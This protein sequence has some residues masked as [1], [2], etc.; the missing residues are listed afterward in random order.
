MSLKVLFIL[1]AVFSL[2]SCEKEA[3]LSRSVILYENDKAGNELVLENEYLELRF[4]PQTAGIVLKEKAGGQVWMS[5]PGVEDN[6]ADMVTKQLMQS[7]FSLTYADGAGVGM[8]LYSGS[9]S[10]E[11]GSF[12]V[13]MVDGGLE[14]HYA[15]GNFARTYLFPAA[16]PEAR[17]LTFLE[18]I[19][20]SDRRK[21]EASYRLYDINNLRAADDKNALLTQ[22]PDLAKSK[23]YVLRDNTQEY[24]KDQIEEFFVGAGYTYDDFL[25]DT[26]RFVSSDG[27]EKPAFNVTIRYEL[28]GSSLVVSV[29]FD[30]IVY[31]SSY[32]ITSLALLP[33]MGS[34]SVDDEGYLLVPD[35][36]GALINFNNGKHNQIAYNNNVYG[37][38]EAMPRDAVISDN[39]AAYPVFGV[40]KNGASLVCIIEEGASYAAVRADVSGRTSS[41]NNVYAQFDMVHGAQMDIS[42]KSDRA[43]YLYETTLPAGEGITERFTPVK[44]GYVAMAEEYRRYLVQKYPHLGTD[45]ADKAGG[46]VPF[47]VEIVGAV[48]KT[49]HRLGFP[50]DLPLKLTSYK[51]AGAMVRD[52]AGFGWENVQVKLTGWFNRS[53]DHSV[54][55]KIKLINELGSKKDFINLVKIT[56]QNGYELFPEADFLF[57]KD[58]SAFDGF[59]LY[60]DA[61]RYVSRERIETYPYSFV[62]FGERFQWGKLSYLARPA[63]QM[64]LID[65]FVKKSGKLGAHNIAFRTIG[66]KLAGDYN[67]KRRVSREASMKM[68]QE[69][70]AG[71]RQSGAGTLVNSGFAYAAPYA[72][73]ITDMALDDQGFGITDV[74]VPFY[75]IALHG[76]VPYSG[77]AINLAEDY[78]KNLL[79]TIESGAGLYFSFMTEETALLQ[80][81]KFRQFY[82]NEYGKWASDADALYQKFKANFR[83][84]YNQRITN[85][86]IRAPGITL[87]EYADGTK[88]FVNMSQKP[89]EQDG[90]RVGAQDFTVVR[91]E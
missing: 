55:S 79:K 34:G 26:A 39:K 77:P 72:S 40:E 32:P 73:F 8:T 42:G 80:E 54:P 29:P 23:V 28:E 60:R 86:E 74:S 46:A 69:K 63:Y 35:G 58:N 76:L 75:A 31:R 67:E 18:K 20:R 16:A 43:V 78:T 41:W 36:S 83:G 84:L 66:A 48:N 12:K 81:T 1:I 82:A 53:V 37:W 22:Y 45:A 21:V 57:M 27:P 11:R 4:L 71:L 38:D 24:M 3:P 2:G 10:V 44:S 62:W 6:S 14:V 52:F 30:K 85:H 56:G 17:M 87:T 13:E 70:L 50:L 64:A 9:H 15:V 65:G 25:L 90:I 68:Q 33:F 89:W 47:A 61:A 51:E 88:V 59:S 7:Q 49:Q 5:N 91:R 19:E